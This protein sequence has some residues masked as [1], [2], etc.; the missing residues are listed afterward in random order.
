MTH[1]ESSYPLPN[2]NG[3]TIEILE[4]VSYFI[5]HFIMDVMVLWLTMIL[6]L[7]SDEQPERCLFTHM[8]KKKWFIVIFH[9]YCCCTN[10]GQFRADSR[11]APSQRETSLQSNTV[12]HWLGA[13]LESA[14]KLDSTKLL[15]V[16][17]WYAKMPQCGYMEQG[18]KNITCFVKK[19][20]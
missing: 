16:C 8:L 19:I 17:Y 9:K 10:M 6:P 15:M 7:L 20:N 3:S 5:P 12:F 2:F 1:S 13:N 4:Y 18:L 14:L 11:L